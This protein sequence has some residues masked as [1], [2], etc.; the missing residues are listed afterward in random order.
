MSLRPH[1]M[2]TVP[3][4]TARVAQAVY[5]KGNPYMTLPDE[6]GFLYTQK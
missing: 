6:L 2:S 5:P 3:A 4:D 1:P